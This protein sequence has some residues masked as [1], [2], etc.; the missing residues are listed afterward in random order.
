MQSPGSIAHL[1]MIPQTDEEGESQDHEQMIRWMKFLEEH[2]SEDGK[3]GVELLKAM[4]LVGE[5]EVVEPVGMMEKDDMGL[6]NG[7]VMDNVDE[8]VEK[9]KK[10]IADAREG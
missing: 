6:N 1:Y 8:Q 5:N 3:G 2:E 9:G 10:S 7:N 4:E